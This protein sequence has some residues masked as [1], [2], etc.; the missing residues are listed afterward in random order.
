[1]ATFGKIYLHYVT[2]AVNCTYVQ[3]FWSDKLLTPE[4][5]KLERL[6]FAILFTVAGMFRVR[7]DRSIL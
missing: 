6:K 7:Q 2:V 4:D 5:A 1:M 3:V